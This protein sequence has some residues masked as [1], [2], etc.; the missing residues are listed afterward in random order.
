MQ[1]RPERF[2]EMRPAV[3]LQVLPLKKQSLLL[4]DD[5]LDNLTLFRIVFENVGYEV[6]TAQNGVDAL[7]VL[8]C[9]AEP[10]LIL[11]DVHMD[12]LSGP[13][14]LQVLSRDGRKIL[15]RV[16]VVF[17]SGDRDVP[18][19]HASGQIR[20]PIDID[21]LLKKVFQYIERGAGHPFMH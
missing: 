6:I 14:F 8:K 7:Q 4:I 3:K 21:Q 5:S 15:E 2:F 11:L 10:D 19:N 20:R 1:T 18:R 12:G 16:P 9:I 13:E 17:F